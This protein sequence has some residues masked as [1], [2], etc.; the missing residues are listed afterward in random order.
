[1]RD[2]LIKPLDRLMQEAQETGEH[3]LKR[4]LGSS[5]LIALG[6]GAIVGIAVFVL[7]GLAS[8]RY[9]G[10][11]VI[12]SF[13][14]AALSCF[15]I[16]LCYAEF[17]SVVP[18]AG[19]AYTYGY[20]TLGEIVAWIIGWDL[21]LEYFFGAAMV[22]WG[23]SGY[24]NS[25]LSNFGIRL[26]PWL[27]GTRWDDFVY[28]NAHWEQLN[29]ILPKL[30]A[31]GISPATL[32]HTHGAFNLLGFLV[33]VA[34]SLIL[35]VGIKESAQFN[36]S[37]VVVNIFV[38]LFFIAIGAQYLFKH[39]ELMAA[40]WH[41]FI[42]QNVGFGHF[43]WSGISRAAAFLFFA[44]IGFDAISTAAQEARNPQKDI[45]TGILGSLAISTCLYLLFAGVLVGLVNY[46]NLDVA[47]PLAVGIDST[48]L[49]WGSLLVTLGAL[50]GLSSTIVVLL[51][52]G[53]RILYSMSRDGLL[54][55]TFSAVHP[56]F[57]T[58][59]ISSVV[60][61]TFAALLAASLP[62]DFLTEMV[63]IGT[64]LAF[65]VVCVG[66][67]VLRRQRPE[68][69]RP[70]M[71][72]WVPLVPIVGVVSI[73][74]MMLSLNPITWLRLATWFVVGLIIYLCYSRSHSHVRQ[75]SAHSLPGG[76]RAFSRAETYNTP[77]REFVSK[78]LKGLVRVLI[79]I[80]G[81]AAILGGLSVFAPTIDQHFQ[82]LAPILSVLAIVIGLLYSVL[83]GLKSVWLLH[84]QELDDQDSDSSVRELID[85]LR[86]GSDG[87]ETKA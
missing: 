49:H 78:L 85:S 8:A 41:P 47:D 66:V 43:G 23:W 44:Y 48:G 30:Q 36:S 34:I 65:S 6:V 2:L 16:G 19:S 62:V 63:S 77:E 55:Q 58:P 80:I 18:V 31:A 26:P 59:Y 50:L 68:M 39:P 29:L 67:W 69:H 61:G 64:L 28:Y 3:S 56:R 37:I 7:T 17:A 15:F 86:K 12:L 9:A 11:A 5:N 32:P 27:A 84:E 1:M 52:G 81:L 22:A 83:P 21:L 40:N 10:P 51:L 79:I 4:S 82:T 71:T 46:H 25:L 53:S 74:V 60:G 33:I 76:I 70:F 57:R 24:L 42:P 13:L 20:A 72:P 14:F 87:S 54:P 75:E 73:F 35:I 45:T 38:L